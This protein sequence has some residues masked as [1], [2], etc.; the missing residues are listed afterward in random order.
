M[1]ILYLHQFFITR[2]GVGGTRSY[3]FARRFAARGHRV[4]M[5]TAGAGSKEQDGIEVVGVRGAYSDYMAATSLSYPRRMLAFARFAL[6][7]TAAAL[8]GPRPDLILASSPPLT[9]AVPAL[10]ARVR[11][12]APFVFEVRDLWPEAPIQMGALRGRT[13]QRLARAL[14]RFVYTRA[15]A[16]VALSPGIR[17]G[18]IAAGSPP[19][20]VELVP[21]ASDLEL[22]SPDLDGRR[23]RERLGLGDSFVCSYF[24]AMG[25]ANDLT[26][27]VE[28]GALLQERGEDAVR[29]VLLGEGKRRGQLEELA[30]RRG[31]ANVV[32][33]DPVPD[34]A[35]VARLAAASDACLTLFK[36]VPVLATNSPN[37]LF[38]TFAAGRPA[39]VNTSGWMR[40]LVERNEAGLFVEPG[41]AADLAEKVLLLRDSPDLARRY[42]RNA[43]ALAER[44]FD[45]DRLAERMLGVLERVAA[46]G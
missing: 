24:G 12:R 38:D 11:H 37:K 23:V 34:K 5:V 25:E 28:A 31:A 46:P 8:K 22:F 32:F 43:R 33:A 10:A 19:A 44:E 26:Q 7:A 3:E 27:V 9:V 18:V 15:A 16:V 45:R 1:R 21:N 20:K 41:D 13:L 6:G 4:R 42:G 30:R 39:I 35:E 2:E 36:D 17:Q 14:E 40:E 29:F